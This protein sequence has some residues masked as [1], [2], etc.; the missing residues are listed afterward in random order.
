MRRQVSP[1]TRQVWPA[2][3][4]GRRVGDRHH[5]Q[6]LHGVRAAVQPAGGLLGRQLAG[7]CWRRQ[8]H[9]LLH[10]DGRGP[11]RRCGRSE[12]HR[13]TEPGLVPA[14]PSCKRKGPCSGLAAWSEGGAAWETARV[15]NSTSP[16]AHGIVPTRER[17]LL[18]LRGNPQNQTIQSHHSHTEALGPILQCLAALPSLLWE[19]AAAEAWASICACS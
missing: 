8:H 4:R 19:P 12:P 18:P 16:R 15:G 7:V 11:E 2:L 13:Q 14:V 10:P 1:L 17:R 9:G 6:R 3:A 5:G